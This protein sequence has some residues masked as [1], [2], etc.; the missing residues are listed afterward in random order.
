VPVFT[1]LTTEPSDSVRF[2]HDRM[3]VILP[4]HAISEWVRPQS[5]PT[6][7]LSSALTDMRYERVP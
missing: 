7:L 3:P 1:I 5:D 6:Q 2:I 4:A